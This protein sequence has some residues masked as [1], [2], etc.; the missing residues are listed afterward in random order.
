[1]RRLGGCHVEGDLARTIAHNF[2][3]TA[4]DLH[5][6]AVKPNLIDSV[7]EALDGF[8]PDEIAH[9]ISQWNGGDAKTIGRGISDYFNMV[10]KHRA[11]TVDEMIELW[12]D[13]LDVLHVTTFDIADPQ[14]LDKAHAKRAITL[15]LTLAEPDALAVV[16]P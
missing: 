5:I 16:T 14:P 8:V 7:H 12:S 1:V 3:E 9:G 10:C 6:L 2:I 13:L 15:A 4:V 11:T